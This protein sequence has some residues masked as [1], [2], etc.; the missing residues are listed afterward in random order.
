LA[1]TWAAGGVPVRISSFRIRL[2][3][4]AFGCAFLGVSLV[5]WWQNLS[6]TEDGYE[7]VE[8]RTSSVPAVETSEI[9]ES[10]AS[11]TR[12]YF[13]K[14]VLQSK[15]RLKAYFDHAPEQVRVWRNGLTDHGA[16]QP[17][18]R[19]VSTY[20]TKGRPSDAEMERD[21]ALHVKYAEWYSTVFRLKT[22]ENQW[23]QRLDR[24]A[25]QRVVLGEAT[26]S[27]FQGY[28]NPDGKGDFDHYVLR[29]MGL[30]GFPADLEYALATDCLR[31][32]PVKKIQVTANYYG[33]IWRWPVDH[34]AAFS[35][36]LELI[37]TGALFTPIVLWIVTG[38]RQYV[39]LHILDEVKRLE[40][41]IRELCQ[42]SVYALSPILAL[43]RVR[44]RFVLDALMS[45]GLSRF[46][47]DS[48]LTTFGQSFIS[49]SDDITDVCGGS[50][51]F[52]P[53]WC[54][55]PKVILPVQVLL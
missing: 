55:S 43:I 19:F 51:R 35:F 4:V 37:L 34:I 28:S 40:R 22:D 30:G 14:A 10:A 2:T 18:P 39:R 53:T 47:F 13:V 41:K 8:A 52:M 11:C 48:P 29:L 1:K 3:A 45:F 16:L 36:G 9:W 31:I 6:A 23:E 54:S 20:D 32:T 27:S 21:A 38:D 17:S 15:F 44:T 42:R 7:W 33:E 26:R 50:E 25:N 49:K 5:D 46:N 12:P 24:V